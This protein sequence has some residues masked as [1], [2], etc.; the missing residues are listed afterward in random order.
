MSLDRF[1]VLGAYIRFPRYCLRILGKLLL[2]GGSGDLGGRNE[3]R[4][5]Q[6]E[7]GCGVDRL[8][9]IPHCGQD[10]CRL[11]RDQRGS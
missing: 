10:V 6:P 7:S 1:P 5:H 2:D 8:A 3:S 4:R 9:P 11:G